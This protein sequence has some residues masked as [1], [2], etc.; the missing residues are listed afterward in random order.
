MKD[1]HLFLNL[2][3]LNNNTP[4]LVQFLD[5]NSEAYGRCADQGQPLYRLKAHQQGQPIQYYAGY[6]EAKVEELLGGDLDYRT[7]VVLDP[8]KK[9]Y[10]VG[11][12]APGTVAFAVATNDEADRLE[13]VF[14]NFQSALNAAYSRSLSP[15]VFEASVMPLDAQGADHGDAFDAYYD[16][17]KETEA[18]RLDAEQADAARDAQDEARNLTAAAK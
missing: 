5:G 8:F 16:E 3:H 10:T 11:I 9:A 18:Y 7:T 2:A 1:P 15:D 14:P 12:L 13:D 4:T 17:P 6:V